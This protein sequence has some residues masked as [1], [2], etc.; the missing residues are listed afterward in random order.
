MASRQ[1]I[2]IGGGTAGGGSACELLAEGYRVVFPV[3]EDGFQDLQ[4]LPAKD[5][6]GVDD[7]GV[8]G[9]S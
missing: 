5:V 4:A 3:D 7:D 2:G 9:Y 1:L 8:T 6:V